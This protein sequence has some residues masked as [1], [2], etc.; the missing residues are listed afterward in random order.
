MWI[1]ADL[2]HNRLSE[3]EFSSTEHHIETMI[4]SITIKKE[5]WYVA[6]CYKNPNVPH[7]IFMSMI[8]KFY[9]AAMCN[10]KEIILLGDMNI[11]M[12]KTNCVLMSDLCN[13]YDLTNLIESPTCF[14]SENGTLID[15]II[16]RNRYRFQSPINVTCG[17][18]DWHNMVGCITKLQVP[19]QK[20]KTIIYRSYKNF[21]E[22]KFRKDVALLP[23]HVGEIFDD[24]SDRYWF[25][26]S[27]Y[28]DVVDE[29]APLKK[30]VIQTQQIPYMTS[31]L[32]HNMYKRNMLK[33][34][35]YKWRSDFNFETYRI[36]RNLTTQMRREAIKNYFLSKCRHAKSPKDFWDCIK[37]FLSKKG[38]RQVN[39]ILN[40]GGIITSNIEEICDIFNNFLALWLIQ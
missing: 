15:P 33:N 16:V 3:L 25:I 24:I 34:I 32:R 30:R 5:I 4:F 8:T 38:N 37:P 11:D 40:D 9:D 36:Q 39:I 22:D 27:L 35:F 6:L 28:K 18:S 19:P 20:P 1:R 23:F 12:L 2:P 17:Y 26:S 10:A 13:V 7:N 31:Q 21:K 29:H 14:K